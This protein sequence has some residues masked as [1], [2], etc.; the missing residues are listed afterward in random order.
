MDSSPHDYLQ[1]YEQAIRRHGAA[2]PSL[3][4]ASRQSQA[5]R[6]SALT[7]AIH[8]AG[9]SVLDAG[10]GQADLLDYLVAQ[11]MP[12]ADYVGVEAMDEH[13][14]AA[15]R[16]RHAN[17]L[18]VKGDFVRE[19]ARLLVGAEIIVFCGSLN[20]MSAGQFYQTLGHAWNAAGRAVV[21][22]FLCSTRLAT[23]SWLTWHR[24]DDVAAFAR[25]LS[26]RMT[27]LEGYLD[28]DATICMAREQD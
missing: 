13:I 22:N 21:F 26:D 17:Y 18:I 8:F 27:L 7:R 25:D 3:L 1:P 2:F 20:T 11:K 6:F 14:A 10:C 24:K 5:A 12:P 28:G 16:K 23:A 19:P 9:R 15:Q 4:W